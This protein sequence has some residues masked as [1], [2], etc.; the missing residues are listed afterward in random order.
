MK[1][2]REDEKTFYDE[3]GWDPILRTPSDDEADE[4]SEE[5]FKPV[6]TNIFCLE[7]LQFTFITGGG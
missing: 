4:E 1:Y 3:G 2:V 7:V 5:E 6:Y